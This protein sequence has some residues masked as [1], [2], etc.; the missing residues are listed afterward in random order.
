[1]NLTSERAI[2]VFRKDGQYG[3]MYST[4]I[5]K[6]QED[7]TYITA[8]I[9]IKFKKGVELQDRT[10]ITIKNG[11]LSTTKDLKIYAFINDFEINGETY[12]E[13]PSDFKDNF[14]ADEVV[15][16]NSDLPF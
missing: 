2:L 3:A 7:G 14:Y 11:W 15:L 13:E 4:G 8:Y 16:D 5:G 9:P 6:K 1:M 10:L 12:K